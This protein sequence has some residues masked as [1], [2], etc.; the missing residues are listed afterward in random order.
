RIGAHGPNTAGT[1]SRS[2][3]SGALPAT[4][5]CPCSL[6]RELPKDVGCE[7]NVPQGHDISYGLKGN[8]C[9]GSKADIAL[10]HSITRLASPRRCG[11]FS[12]P[13]AFEFLRLTTS[14]NVVGCSIGKSAGRAPF[15]ILLTKAAAVLTPFW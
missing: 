6:I 9:F 1:S 4:C 10:T 11:A 14:S 2:Y 15:S 8:V 5:H 13:I 3:T 7:C 12:R